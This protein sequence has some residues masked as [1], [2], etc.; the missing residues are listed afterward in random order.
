MHFS[1]C[2][3]M[4][5][6]TYLKEAGVP[7]EEQ[8]AFEEFILTATEH[9]VKMLAAESGL[10][11]EASPKS[12][13]ERWALKRVA[14]EQIEKTAVIRQAPCETADGESGSWVLYDA[15]GTK[16]LGCHKTREA[17]EAQERAIQ[18]GKH[19]ALSDPMES[20]GKVRGRAGRAALAKR[21]TG[22]DGSFSMTRC[23]EAMGDESGITDAA[24]F[25]RSL[26]GLA[27]GGYEATS[28][29]REGKLPGE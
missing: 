23:M 3:K 6:E 24:S 27:R 1:E 16:K 10:A 18:A 11:K 15:A 20:G 4:G 29:E 25:C 2:F 28:G 8:D 19:A 26:E 13:F 12:A 5:I 9:A 17:A 14:E 22:A 21:F 7:E